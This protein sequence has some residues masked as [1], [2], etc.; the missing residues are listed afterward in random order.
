MGRVS[1]Y[2]IFVCTSE[3]VG[4]FICFRVRQ[5]HSLFRLKPG[6]AQV[7]RRQLPLIINIFHVKGLL[8]QDGGSKPNSNIRWLRN[9]HRCERAT[10][11]I[12]S[13]RGRFTTYPTLSHSIDG[14]IS[15]SQG[16]SRKMV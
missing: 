4:Y 3:C 2:A 11:K 13:T 15:S 9:C 16:S 10:P 1:R 8:I 6:L 5:S 7:L 12:P 14:I